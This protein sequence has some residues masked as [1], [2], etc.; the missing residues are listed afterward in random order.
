[1]AT[2]RRWWVQ[3][4]KT[5]QSLSALLLS[6]IIFQFIIPSVVADN[7]RPSILSDGFFSLL[8]VFG[9]AAA[10]S[11]RPLIFC[12]I[13]MVTAA[14]LI[15]RWLVHFGS[16][17]LSAWNAAVDIV[18]LL[19]FALVVLAK[20]LRRGTVTRYRIQGAVVVYLLIGFIWANAYEWTALVHPH[21]FNNAGGVDNSTWIYYSFVTLTTM[22]YGD[23]TP[24]HSTARSLAAAEALTG[25]LY[26]A[27]LISRL[28]A[29]EITSH[30]ESR[31]KSEPPIQD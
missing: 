1:M 21:A 19:S 24:V 18:A 16:A 10:A 6:L 8:F 23:I 27:I 3:Y 28:V 17:D 26:L 5:D 13:V 15:I 30:Q 31:R 20:V 12:L 7:S 25:Q 2:F 11:E 22:G 14:A 9:I 29:L 4:W